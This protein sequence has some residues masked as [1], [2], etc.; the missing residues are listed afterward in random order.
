MDENKLKDDFK[1]RYIV[2]EKEPDELL[3]R[4]SI[5]LCVYGVC[6]YLSQRKNWRRRKISLY[7]EF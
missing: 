7:A 6:V 2:S 4:N 5:Y 3:F 1:H